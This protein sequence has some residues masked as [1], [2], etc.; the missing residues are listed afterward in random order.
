MAHMRQPMGGIG[1]GGFCGVGGAG[2]SGMSMGQ[3]SGARPHPQMVQQMLMQNLIKQNPALAQNP[4]A[5]QHMITQALRQQH[6]QG[7]GP[8]PVGGPPA[9]PGMAGVT[10][11]PGPLAP[12][13]TSKAAGTP[14]VPVPAPAP[15]PGA[16]PVSLP[17]GECGAHPGP[18]NST[19]SEEA[20]RP[21]PELIKQDSGKTGSIDKN[22][23]VKVTDPQGNIVEMQPLQTF[24]ECP[25]PQ[26]LQDEIQ[27]AGFTKP[28]QIQAYAWPIALQGQDVVGIA[29]TGSGKT[30]AFLFPAFMHILNHRVGSRDPT[31]LVLAPTR[32][33][34]VQI[35][36]EATRFGNSSRILT[37]CAYGGAPKFEQLSKLRAGC[38]CLIATPGRLNDFLEG[39][40]VRLDQVCKMVLDEADR[41]LDMGFEP[42]IR[43]ILK[44]VPHKRHTL[45]FT[46]TWPKEVRKLAEDFLHKPYQVQIGDRNELKANADIT[47]IVKIVQPHEKNTI[48]LQTLQEYKIGGNPEHRSLVFCGTKRMCDQLE[49]DFQRASFR[50]AAIHGDKD[51]RQRDDALDKFRSGTVTI[52]VATDV[53]ARGLDIKGVVLV[54]NY[55][56]ANNA[57]DYV[58]RI[59]RTGRAG[60]KGTAVTFLTADQGFKAA[61]I[62]EIMDKTSQHV[63]EELRKLAASAP[64]GKGKGK[65]RFRDA[66]GERP[67]RD[68][69]DDHRGGPCG[70]GA[71]PGALPAPYGS[72]GGF[73]GGFA[74][75]RGVPTSN[76]FN[77]EENRVSVSPPKRRS[78]SRRER[79]RSRSRRGDDRRGS[80]ERLRG[81]GRG[82][83]E[84]RRSGE[85]RRDDEDR[86]SGDDLKGDEVTNVNS[87][88][89]AQGDRGVEERRIDERR[90]EERRGDH[91][92][93]DRRR[94]D[95]R[96]D[97]RADDRRGDDRRRDD[98][99]GDERRGDDR[100]RGGDRRADYERRGDDRK[101]D[102]RRR[103]S[104][105]R[106]Q[107]SRSQKRADMDDGAP[108]QH[109]D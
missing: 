96:R 80:D 20:G 14:P 22:E 37:V 9:P 69:R 18:G 12:Q 50:I 73:G 46:A 90:G 34:A 10:A 104:R 52:L 74:G 63:S 36:K 16:D 7:Q 33:L 49:R 51:Q 88:R 60:Q 29:A 77:R 3:M 58:H 15:A 28:S 75:T 43:K 19:C 70:G 102:D 17:A 55:D 13:T 4:V 1:M 71:A 99:R 108:L 44:E 62:V 101:G 98:R 2:G 107:R 45:F 39:K 31:L 85:D 79:R 66:D 32:E 11:V 54:I 87:S 35:E 105:S 65:G 67:G 48:L 38:H 42:Q 21:V 5:A 91:K 8:P 82:G 84:E 25:F 30:I 23:E 64:V 59:G 97:R 76:P 86:R 26:A 103:R 94:D 40:Q 24:T 81:D 41:M 27:K 57:E 53:A 83:L 61:G 72:A 109:A 89:E 47:Q 6:L 106:R 95:D 78:R 92:R 56:P 93:E 100:R 68:E